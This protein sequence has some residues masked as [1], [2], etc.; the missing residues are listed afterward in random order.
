MR[1]AKVG[2]ATLPAAEATRRPRG[3]AASPT[4]AVVGGTAGEPTSSAGAVAVPRPPAAE[5]ELV[6]APT[7]HPTGGPME[8]GVE[9]KLSAGVS[10]DRWPVGRTSTCVRSATGAYESDNF[11]STPI[12]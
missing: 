5:A 9:A 10:S 8:G 11:R 4:A 12:Y 3:Q 7:V 2:G 6:V 1:E